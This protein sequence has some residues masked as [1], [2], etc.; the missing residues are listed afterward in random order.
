MGLKIFNNIFKVCDIAKSIKTS[1]DL[2]TTTEWNIDQIIKY[3]F[4]T[5]FVWR[6]PKISRL[7]SLFLFHLLQLL[8]LISIFITMTLVIGSF[9][10][11]GLLVKAFSD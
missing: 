1:L 7:T 4:E 6:C 2:T 10:K 9:H 3:Y 8:P 5:L 11:G